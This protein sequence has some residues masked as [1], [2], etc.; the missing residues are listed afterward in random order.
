MRI[1]LPSEGREW[2][3]CWI[4]GLRIEPAAVVAMFQFA[5]PKTGQSRQAGNILCCMCM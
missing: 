1:L 5:T 2:K 3:H 4:V